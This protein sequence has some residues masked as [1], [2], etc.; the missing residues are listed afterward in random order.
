ME[1]ELD[2]TTEDQTTGTTTDISESASEPTTGTPVSTSEEKDA[3]DP[4]KDA[5]RNTFCAWDFV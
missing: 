4:R 2:E 3:Y 1:E 5:P